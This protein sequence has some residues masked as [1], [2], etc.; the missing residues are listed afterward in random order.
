MATAIQPKVFLA[1]R[2]AIQ[3]GARTLAEERFPGRQGRLL[4]AYLVAEAGRPVARDELADALWG[5][6][7]PPTW[8]KSLTVVV[9]KLRGLLADVGLDEPGVLTAAFGCYRLELPPGSWVDV[10]IAAN[11]VHDAERALLSGQWKVAKTSASVADSILRE[12]FLPGEGGDWVEEKRR[13]FADLRCRVT[14]ALTDACLRSGDL[15]EATHWGEQAIS[16]AP[17][18]EISYRRLMEVHAAAGNRAEALQVYERCRRLLAEELGAYPSPETESMFRRLLAAPETEGV[19][20]ASSRRVSVVGRDLAGSPDDSASVPG[21]RRGQPT[22][23]ARSR[24]MALLATAGLLVVGA[25]TGGAVLVLD[26]GSAGAVR[27]DAVA[28]IPI[29]G[30]KGI[31]YTNVGTTPGTVAYGAGGVWVLNADDR[32]ITSIDPATRRVVKTFATGSLPT[33]LAAGAGAV[34]LGSSAA[35]RGVIETLAQTAVLSRVDAGSTEV[36]RSVRLPGPS[37]YFGQSPGLSAVAV[38]RGA[39]WAVDPDGSIAR[40]DPA[41]G[42][43]I[44]RIPSTGAT[45]IAVGDAGVWFVTI[46]GRGPAVERVDPRTNRVAQRIPVQTSALVG[47]AVGAGSIWATDPSSGVIWRIQPGPPLAEQTIPGGLG[48]TQIAFGAGD[49]WAAND[50]TGSVMRI[51][52]QTN[53][54]TRTSRIAGT[55][56]GLAVGDGKVWVSVAA[57]TSLRSSAVAGCTPVVSG[58]RQP[59]VLVASDFPLQGPSIARTFAAAVR[60]VLRQHGFRASRYTVGYQSCDDSTAQT[61]GSDFLKCAANGRAFSA[62]EKLVAVIGPYDSSCA[63]VE[64]PITNRAAGGPIAILSPSNTMPALT[65]SDPE[66]PA[67]A[68]GI[69]YPV[70]MRSYL[71]LASPDDLEGAADAELA[72]ALGLRRLF[73]L[74]DNEEYG[75]ALA[76]G[77]RAA[78]SHLELD[79]VGSETWNPGRRDYSDVVAA[80]SHARAT[81][82]FLTGFNGGSVGLVRSLRRAFGTHL[83]IIAGDGFLTIPQTERMLG[84][85]ADGMY[86]SDSG[87]PTASLTP[88]GRRLLSAFEAAQHGSKIPSGTYLPEL[89]QAAEAVVVAIARS[90]GTR[91]SVLREL[92]LTRISN[93]VFGSFHFDQ[94][95]DLTPAPFMI[96]HITGGRGD[97]RLAPDFRGSVVY[98]VIDASTDL[99]SAS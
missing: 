63:R 10:L 12:S 27:E 81:G 32:T 98:R 1:G 55:P 77:F 3:A 7:K 89:L 72:R 69:L 97:A 28:A 91:A 13:E 75:D 45:T 49:I 62:A 99:L 54:V 14:S 95:G 60:F 37:S 57:G 87:V 52:P 36:T 19:A 41:T 86:V 38:G 35:E 65:R 76:R 11:A 42:S 51:D 26:G 68:P 21:T 67:G 23:R 48:V 44:A 9:S 47:I 31:S 83:T 70:G 90:D 73:I 2:V 56:Q 25:A 59:D 80:L 66:G 94:N 4:F 40:I 61:Q 29:S 96:L 58:G 50:A 33:D 78:A 8:E 92:R 64:I 82:V 74:S 16:L 18:R 22:S 15:V 71:R 85:A 17:F 5:D 24:R 6:A 53:E 88:A 43:V 46:S 93:G 84:P 79:L 39:V 34:W 30:H 20:G